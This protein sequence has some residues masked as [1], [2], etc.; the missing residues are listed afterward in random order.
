MDQKEVEGVIRDAV[1]RC[2]MNDWFGDRVEDLAAIL[3]SSYDESVKFTLD[4]M[5][6]DLAAL[7]EE[8]SEGLPVEDISYLADTLAADLDAAGLLDPFLEKPAPIEEEKKVDEEEEEEDEEEAKASAASKAKKAMK[9]K[10]KGKK[11]APMK[12]KDKP[13][14]SKV[15]V[16]VK[17]EEPKETPAWLTKEALDAKSKGKDVN[18]LI[19]MQVLG[20]GPELLNSTNLILVSGRKYGLIGLNGAGK[21][22][23]LTH[24]SKYMFHDFPKHLHVLHVQQEVVGDSTLVIDHVMK[25]DERLQMLLREQKALEADKDNLTAVQQLRLEEVYRSLKDIDAFSAEGRAASILAGLQF[26]HEMIR[27]KTKDLSGGW[28]MR[29]ALASAL[30][31]QPDVLLLDE[32]TNHLD[33][34]AV[35]WLEDYLK[36]YKA[37]LVVVSHDRTFLN[38]VI[39]DVIY[40][41]RKKLLYYRGNYDTFQKVREEQI[42]TTNKAFAIQQ[43]KIAHQTEFINRW[44]A[45]KKL[46]SM[47]Q[48]RIKVLDKMEKVE[49]IEADRGFKWA[50]PKPEPLRKDLLVE[51][52]NVKFGYTK[53]KILFD[54]VNLTI[55]LDSRVGILGANGAG[56]STL[57]KLIMQQEDSLEGII[58]VNR[59]AIVGYFAQHHVD[60]LDVDLSSLDYLRKTFPGA[61]PEDCFKQLS[62]YGLKGKIATQKI[63]TLSGGQKS[64]VS[65]AVM[66]WSNPHLIILDEPTN[67]CDMLTIDALIDAVNSFE[68][69]VVVVSHDQHFLSHVCEEFWAVGKGRVKSFYDFKEASEYSYRKEDYKFEQTP[70]AE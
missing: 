52:T 37:T 22:T 31:V 56:K 68:G 21:S 28:R 45:N 48:S 66:T 41:F 26:S 2:D 15:K 59:Q 6:D 24:I 60:N 7:L 12:K 42:R 25:S 49:K 33:F 47:V 63:S 14:S 11:G 65:F 64:R 4:A 36:E 23:L 20:G 9:G 39:T 35:K 70:V 69:A 51:V 19:N 55:R 3:S 58:S 5:K 10:K 34:P 54:D 40:L 32:P 44:R 30:F 16:K 53:D 8:I 62:T 18:I 1:D 50:F 57:I 61:T 43:D 46:S 17:E 67:H 38:N 13:K 29:V 27:Y